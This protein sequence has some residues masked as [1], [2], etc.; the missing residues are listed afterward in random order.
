[1]NQT[2]ARPSKGGHLF[3]STVFRLPQ[4]PC[5]AA[6]NTCRH[7]IRL[8]EDRVQVIL[9]LQS[10]KRLVLFMFHMASSRNAR[11]RPAVDQ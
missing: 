2:F 7:V 6:P 1:M 11:G 9:P 5:A 3:G 4:V 8:L 10:A